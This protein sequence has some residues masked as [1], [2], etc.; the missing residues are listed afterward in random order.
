[1][2]VIMSVKQISVV[3]PNGHS[4]SVPKEDWE[5]ELVEVNDKSEHGMGSEKH[6]RYFIDGYRCPQCDKDIDA[7]VDVWEY[8][9]G[10]IET[11]DKS[12]NVIDDVGDSFDAELD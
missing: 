10:G 1:M 5:H 9:D 11:T 2:S 6:H 8:P 7:S 3:C 4:V 12:A